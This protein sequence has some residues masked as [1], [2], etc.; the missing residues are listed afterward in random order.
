MRQMKDIKSLNL[1][2]AEIEHY[3]CQHIYNQTN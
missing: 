2:G 1:N 3:H